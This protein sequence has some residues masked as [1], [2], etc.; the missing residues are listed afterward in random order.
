MTEFEAFELNTDTFDKLYRDAQANS[1]SSDTGIPWDIGEVQPRLAELEAVGGISGEV[2]DVGCGFGDNAI[3]LASRG[4]TVTGVD[5][6]AAAIDEAR[7]RAQNAGVNVTFDVAD[8]T[9]LTGYDP[10]FDTVLDNALYHCLDEDGRRSY[11]AT[12]HRVTR[13]GAR[14]FLNCFSSATINGILAPLAAVPESNLRQTLSGAGWR[15]DYLGAS[16]YKTTTGGFNTHWEILPPCVREAY[17]V[18]SIDQIRRL[19]AHVATVCE[20]ID[21]PATLP[22]TAVFAT[23]L[24]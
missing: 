7:R 12:L 13:R 6:S 10:R 3:F 16:S 18:E 9:R 19:T 11:A 15:I 1:L 4:H 23:R 24:D 8:A 20:L 21:A 17:P 2:L 5:S 22:T 14:L